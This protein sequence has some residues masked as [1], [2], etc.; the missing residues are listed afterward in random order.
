MRSD[1]ISINGVTPQ[2]SQKTIAD[3]ETPRIQEINMVHVRGNPIYGYMRYDMGHEQK[4]S[5]MSL[6]M[7][8]TNTTGFCEGAEIHLLKPIPSSHHH[9]MR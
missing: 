9:E 5:W 8:L 2:A 7:K 1:C 6:V 3:R 4:T